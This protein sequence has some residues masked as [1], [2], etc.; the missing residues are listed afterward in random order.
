[1]KTPTS[2]GGNA[3]PFELI[4]PIEPFEQIFQF[5]IFSTFTIAHGFNR[6][7]GGLNNK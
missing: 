2:A 1:V 5:T 4:E 7:R 3:Q 6:G